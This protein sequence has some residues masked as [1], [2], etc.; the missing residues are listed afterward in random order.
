MQAFLRAGVHTFPAPDALRGTGDLLQRQGHRAGSFAG[1]AGNAQSLIPLNLYKAEPVEPAIDCPQRAQ[2]L[3]KGPVNLRR[4]QHNADQ[5]S[6]LPEKQATC[7]TPKLFICAQQRECA[8]QGAGWAQIFAK[9]RNFCE[10]SEQKRG[11][12]A[13]QKNQHSIFSIF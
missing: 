1:M 10:L 4:E 13:H 7:L 11:A 12:N 2:I 3:A 8:K 9:G 6:Q 5:D